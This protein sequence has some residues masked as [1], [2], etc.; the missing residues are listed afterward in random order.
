MTDL[1]HTSQCSSNL[2]GLAASFMWL[3]RHYLL[4]CQVQN[5]ENCK[6]P[7]SSTVAVN[8]AGAAIQ[9]TPLVLPDTVC[10]DLLAWESHPNSLLRVLRA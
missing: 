1:W 2:A 6:A 10:R 4:A 7:H 9:N 3:L 5:G 8:L